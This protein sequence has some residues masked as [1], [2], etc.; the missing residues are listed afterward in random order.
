MADV[1]AVSL[2]GSIIRD[3]QYKIVGEGL[4]LAKFMISSE[5]AKKDKA[6]VPILC[7]GLIADQAAEYAKGDNVTLSGKIKTGSYLNKEGLKV[8]TTEIEAFDITKT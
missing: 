3:V 6:F 7:W 1:N 5:G 2:S 4:S 8:Y